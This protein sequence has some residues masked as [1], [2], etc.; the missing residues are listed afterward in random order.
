MSSNIDILTRDLADTIRNMQNKKVTPYDTQAT[1]MRIED[2]VAWVHIPGGVDETPVQMTANAKV[3]DT[4]QVRV[5]GGQAWLYG[6]ATAP[7]TDDTIAKEAEKK[8]IVADSHAI[9]AITSADLAKEAADTAQEYAETARVITDEITEYA[10]TAGKTVTQIL[11]D[12][13]TAGEMARQA[14]ASANS[15]LKGLSTVEDVVDTLNWIATHCQY[16]KTTDTTIDPNK[17]YYTLAVAQVVSPTGSPK[18]NG[19][20]EGS[21]DP[22]VYSKTSDTS[23]VS[24]KTYYT[25]VGIPVA[26]PVVADIGTYYELTITKAVSDYINTHVAV[27]DEGLWLLPEVGGNKVLI[28]VGGSG[29]VYAQAG[30]YILDANDNIMAKF[31]SSGA[32]VGKST[33]AHSIVDIDGQRFYA[34]DGT[35]QLANIGYGEGTSES[36]ISS[37]PF[38]TFGIRN[39]TI[40]S[41]YDP[42]VIYDI[43][44]M[45]I[46]DDGGGDKIY[47]R[48]YPATGSGPWNSNHWTYYIGNYSFAEGSNVISAGWNAH[49]EGS[50]TMAIG[51]RSHAEGGQ[52]IAARDYSHAE[53]WGTKTR[54]IASHAE[55]KDTY[56]IGDQSHAQNEGTVATYDWQTVLGKYNDTSAGNVAVMI[57]NGT[58]QNVPSNAL[59]V[60]WDGHVVA[61]SAKKSIMYTGEYIVLYGNQDASTSAGQVAL[62]TTMKN[63]L[64]ANKY[65]TGM[66]HLGDDLYSVSS[67]VITLKKKGTY[68]I[69]YQVYLYSGFTANDYTTTGISYNNTLSNLY[70]SRMRAFIANPYSTCS[71]TT[72]IKTTAE[73]STVSLGVRNDSAARGAI[74]VNGYTRLKVTCL[75]IYE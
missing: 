38:Y 36:G 52:S 43:G 51:Y 39:M 67:G 8:A 24:G 20:Y 49:A 12:G 7:P 69:E 42:T 13:E 70:S 40:P 73:N 75:G 56:A 44:D 2:N 48:H 1:V 17:I 35:T 16:E 31:V 63:V 55:G 65:D 19:Y 15:A 59:T 10:D 58:A 18:E 27:T 4:V 37:A 60:D 64:P 66:S 62:E 6:N 25:V 9:D 46:Y 32:Q 72:V 23:V 33:G 68:S 34:I 21:G 57:G 11:T 28:A 54:G 22:I 61:T 29:H 50:N 45:C 26:S 30:T 71:G 53:G 74:G 3:G 5:S 47:V 14:T 41:R